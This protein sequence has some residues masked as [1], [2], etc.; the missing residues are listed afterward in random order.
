MEGKSPERSILSRILGPDDLKRLNIQELYI[1]AEEIRQKIISVVSETGGHLAPNLGVV[2]LTIAIH[3]VF[4]APRDMIIWD[5][6][7]QT[8]TH[9]LLTGNLE[10]FHTLRQYGGLSGFP[11]KGET[12]YDPFTMGHSGTSI[13]LALGV[14]EARCLKKEDYHVIAIIG[15]GS[16]TSGISFE[17]LNQAGDREK[18]LIV[19]L[20]DNEMSISS[21]VG[22][23]SSYLSRIMTGQFFTRF[24]NEMKTFLKTLPGVGESVS[25]IIKKTEEYLKGF[26]T[27]GLIFEELGFKY[28][29]P[30]DGHRLEHLIDTL[31]NVSHIKGPILVHVVTKKGKGYLPAEKDP[32][33]FHGTGPFDIATGKPKK[34]PDNPPTYTE[35]FG[36]TLIKL[37]RKDKRIVAITAAM[38]TGTGLDEFAREFPDRFFDVGIAEQHA[39]TF[40]AGLASRGF[41]P[42]VAIYSTF[43]QRA[44]DQILHD[45]CLQNLPVVFAIDR[46]GIVG[47]DGQ[48]HQGIFDFSYLRHIPNMI[49]M[50]PKDENELRSMMVTAL[51]QEDHP[52]SFRYPRGRGIGVPLDD[53]PEPLEIG[54]GEVII[55]GSDL[56]ILAIGS[57]VL[58]SIKAANILEREGIR[59]T[60]VNCRFVKPLDEEL[61][62]TLMERIDRVITVE[63]NVLDGGF[64]SAV[65]EMME[66]RGIRKVA[67]KRIGIPNCFVEHGSQELLREKY[68][69]D[70]EGIANMA[71]ELIYAPT[72]IA[73]IHHLKG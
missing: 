68:G 27:P 63:E 31:R 48:T 71:R 55:K 21:N 51:S 46:G 72:F 45:V 42:V 4:N 33:M 12:L 53:D 28:V 61:L 52:I 39:V 43:L 40:A 17:G 2:E 67:I 18:D 14:A 41:R 10:R 8:Y 69:L 58:P 19:I 26:I 57:M 54:K 22:A 23:L 1:L 6:G 35:V 30:I 47:E 37:A 34:G 9:K 20:N 32:I 66:R 25:K 70:P 5:V 64:G 50:A 15:D 36:K 59:S 3:Y 29:G 11:L 49:I 56:L 65:L 62:S 13:S 7:H 60:V 73:R 24:R 44:Y 38:R 16:T